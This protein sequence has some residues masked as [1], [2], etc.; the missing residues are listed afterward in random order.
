MNLEKP[1]AY[2]RKKNLTA[3]NTLVGQN[4]QWICIQLFQ[5]G[6]A[7]GSYESVVV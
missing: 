5:L 6:P 3:V 2:A 7:V 1:D 4:A